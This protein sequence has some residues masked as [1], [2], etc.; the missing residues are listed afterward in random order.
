M[1]IVK[2]VTELRERFEN[3]TQDVQELNR[4]EELYERMKAAGLIKPQ[5]YNLPQPDT[6]GRLL[7]KK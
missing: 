3:E 6:I 2:E 5:T 1:N 7:A 4:L